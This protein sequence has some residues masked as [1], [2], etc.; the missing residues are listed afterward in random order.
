MITHCLRYLKERDPLNIIVS[1][2]AGQGAVFTATLIA[3][4]A[5]KNGKQV[6]QTART[7]AAVR[8]GSSVAHVIISA[9]MVDFP[10]VDA[11]DIILVLSDRGRKDLPPLSS[12]GVL[13]YDAT[14]I[15][16]KSIPSCQLTVPIPASK[17]ADGAGLAD[18]NMVLAGAVCQLT[19]ILPFE[20][21][22]EVVNTFPV[23][24]RA[25][26]RQALL[27][28]KSVAETLLEQRR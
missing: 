5:A 26:D 22:I 16:R 20:L 17:A 4:A 19:H 24:S 10:Y 7:S 23:F 6:A 11:A 28:G 14:I 21:L 15:T 3:K 9:A 2:T 8:D 1:G 27:L 25:P 18:V 13:F 12:G